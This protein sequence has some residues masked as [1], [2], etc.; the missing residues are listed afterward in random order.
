VTQR[1]PNDRIVVGDHQ[2]AQGRA[3]GAAGIELRAGHL[4]AAL[5]RGLLQ[6]GVVPGA[7]FGGC[8]DLT[9]GCSHGPGADHRSAPLD[10]VGEQL[11]GRTVMHR[12]APTPS[13]ATLWRVA[14]MNTATSA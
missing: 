12:H 8:G 6:H 11:H 1:H 5:E 2:A 4:E 14:S 9:R 3:A 13:F 7:C 10:L